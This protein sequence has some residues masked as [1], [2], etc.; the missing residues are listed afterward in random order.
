MRQGSKQE[1]EQLK[2]KQNNKKPA[3]CPHN[4]LVD[5]GPKLPRTMAVCFRAAR[6]WRHSGSDDV[7]SAGYVT[8]PEHFISHSNNVEECDMNARQAWRVMCNIL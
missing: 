8:G 1:K 5:P 7:C 4:H 6:Q 2:K 3:N